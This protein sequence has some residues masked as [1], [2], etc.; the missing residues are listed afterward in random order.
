MCRNMCHCTRLN[1]SNIDVNRNF[2][3]RKPWNTWFILI[4]HYMPPPLF[5]TDL[6]PWNSGVR[7]ERGLWFGVKIQVSEVNGA[8]GSVL[9]RPS[10]VLPSSVQAPLE[11][12]VSLYFLGIF[13]RKGRVQVY[14]RVQWYYTF[15]T[16]WRQ[17]PS[18]L[19]L[20]FCVCVDAHA[21]MCVWCEYVVPY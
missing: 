1:D 8:S 13:P 15:P 11:P 2:G 20:F 17:E 5:S 18:N 6:S 7:G 10:G 14:A 4:L 16:Y 12:G 9:G 19:S 3:A 21:C